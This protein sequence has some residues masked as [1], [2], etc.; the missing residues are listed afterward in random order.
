MQCFSHLSNVTLVTLTEKFLN[1]IFIFFV[2]HMMIVIS[3]KSIIRCLRVSPCYL[4]CFSS[5]FFFLFNS[6]CFCVWFFFFH[7]NKN[8][9]GSILHANKCC[10]FLLIYAAQK[11]KFSIKDFFSKCDESAVSCGFGHIYW[12]NH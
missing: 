12:I 10:I 4:L 7:C 6:V 5:F 1:G 8:V 3:Q 11:M 9:K 2:M